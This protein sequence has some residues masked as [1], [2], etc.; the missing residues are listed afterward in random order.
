VVNREADVAIVGAGLAGLAAARRL[1]AAGREV[2][3]LEARDRPGGRVLNHPIGDGKVVELGAQWVGP[4][5]DRVLALISE[6]GLETFPTHGDGEHLFERN[7]RVRRHRG[8]I[9]RLN[10]LGLVETGVVLGRINRLA[11]L[12]DPATPWTA[13]RAANWDSQTFETWIRRRIRTSAARDLMRLVI[14]GVWAAEPRDLSLLHMLFYV[15]SA[16]S[17]EEL[18]DTEGGAQQDRVVGGTQL[19]AARITE[20]LGD[21]LVLGAP[22]RAIVHGDAGVGIGAGE[23]SVSAR[24]AIIALA[25]PLAGRIAYDP[26]LPAARDGLSARMAMGT[27]VKCHAVYELPWWRDEGLSGQ[28]TSTD[29]PVSVVFD[30]SPPDGSPG[31]LLAFFEGA[32]AREASALDQ[33]ERRQIVGECLARMFGPA[34]HEPQDYTDMAWANEEWT[35]GCY[36]AFMPPG[37]WTDHGAALRRPIGPLHWAGT[38]TATAWSGY[39][40]GAVRSGERAADEVLAALAG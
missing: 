7:G 11:R 14:N 15:S 10:P 24:R 19:I 17:I 2:V 31:V 3:V 37:T 16:G 32:A 12:V 23:V 5:Q 1:R 27:V 4:T 38:E 39:M 25:P 20:E 29:G 26:P 30:N 9:P 35:R 36:G 13:K 6:L 40:D 28:A 33:S 8:T 21:T 22:V 18:L 34:A